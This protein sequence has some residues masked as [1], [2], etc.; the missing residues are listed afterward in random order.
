MK[1]FSMIYLCGG[2]G[3]RTALLRPKQLGSLNGIPMMIYSLLAVA[4]ID[5]VSEIVINYPSGHLQDIKDVLAKYHIV[6][7]VVYVPA[8]ATRQESV[9]AMLDQCSN[10]HVIVHE[11]ARPLASE[12]MFRDIVEHPSDNVSFLAEVPFSVAVV[13]EKKRVVVGNLE[14]RTLRNIQ[15]PQKFDRAVLISAHLRAKS[16]N[17]RYTE[18]TAACLDLGGVEIGYLDGPSTNIKVTYPED[19]ALVEMI[20]RGEQHDD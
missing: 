17:K 8:G 6:K 20:I 18:D 9:M 4:N 5:E 11:A 15:L 3:K 7:P 10:D 14:R 1:Q 13:S 2:I 19:L 16:L 12:R